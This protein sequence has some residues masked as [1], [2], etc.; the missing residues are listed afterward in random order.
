[1]ATYIINVCM[2]ISDKKVRDK[3][4]VLVQLFWVQHTSLSAWYF[5]S[6]DLIAPVIPKIR[7]L[8]F[9]GAVMH[10]LLLPWLSKLFQTICKN[11]L[12]AYKAKE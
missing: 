5:Y 11:K 3:T 8:A 10:E 1:M 6:Y 2:P 12:Q 9:P 4:V 7:L